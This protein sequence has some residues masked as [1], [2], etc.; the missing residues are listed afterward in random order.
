MNFLVVLP[1]F[2]DMS[3]KIA[4]PSA[5]TTSS[6]TTF[7]HEAENGHDENP[8]TRVRA[9]KIKVCAIILY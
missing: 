5:S 4:R 7:I 1:S 6:A 8:D 2:L 3:T 9:T